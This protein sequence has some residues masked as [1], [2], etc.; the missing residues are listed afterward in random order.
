M[1]AYYNENNPYCAEWLKN[2]IA[3]GH[4]APGD[5]DERD[6][7]DVTPSDLRG[8]TQCHFFAGIGVWSYALR[9]AHWPDDRPV[10][11]GSCPCQPFSTAGKGA[12]FVDERHLWPHWFH[13]IQQCQPPV[14]FGE[15]VE[16][17]IRHGWLD[18]VQSDL[19]G[20]GYAFAAA[21]LPAASVGAPHVR[22]RLWFVADC[23]GARLEG[24]TGQEL[25]R[26]VAR[27]ARG[28]ETGELDNAASH[29]QQRRGA[30]GAAEEG[31]Q[32][33]SQPTWQLPNGLEGYRAVSELANGECERPQGWLF[34]GTD[35]PWPVEHGQVGC[36][37]AA[38]NANDST[39]GCTTGNTNGNT[40]GNGANTPTYHSTGRSVDWRDA[41]WIYCRDGRWRAV[42]PS[43]FP[44]VDGIVNRVGRL[45]A[46]G[47]A[48]VPQVA[49]EV[50]T[51]YMASGR[52]SQICNE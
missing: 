12:G 22:Q 30:C 52:D 26:A 21:G 4:I 37:S 8:Y 41:D 35:A 40:T 42:E 11:T 29:G 5:I 2:L 39:L 32:A 49:Q 7:R 15:Q 36:D 51:A 45:R 43:A 44:L 27:F 25:Q 14:I 48:I 6:I 34:G 38:G 19:E 47:N 33:Q 46:Y 13:L 17:A 3:A 20:M 50:I 18:L 9:L 24:C 1:R 10:W 31:A 23:A 16:A 28:G